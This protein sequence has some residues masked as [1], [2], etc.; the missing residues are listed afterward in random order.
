LG[1]VDVKDVPHCLTGTE[2]DT[3]RSQ[4]TAQAKPSPR[5][6]GTAGYPMH[7]PALVD[8]E[9]LGAFLAT[10][11]LVIVSSYWVGNQFVVDVAAP[12]PAISTEME[13]DL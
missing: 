11:R 8:V 12:A 2:M 10:R 7:P 3:P 9:D 13:F 5:P 4:I 6:R 1:R